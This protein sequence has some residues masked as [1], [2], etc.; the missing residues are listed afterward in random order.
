MSTYG[1]RRT[2][3]NEL[4]TF[5]D[6]EP[7]NLYNETI[8]RKAKQM[9]I[10]KNLGLLDKVSDL[11]ASILALK[12]KSEFSGIIRETGLDKFLVIY[13]SPNSYFYINNSIEQKK[14]AH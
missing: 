2:K 10:D 6:V 8:L 13:F 3:A 9:N 4:I 12:Y 5:G 11:V 14:Q 7:V 1:W